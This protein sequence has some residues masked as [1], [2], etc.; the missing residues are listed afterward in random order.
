MSNP[1]TPAISA[2]QRVL[3][4]L[5]VRLGAARLPEL[6]HA[7][8]LTELEVLDAL[9]ELERCGQVAPTVWRLT[10]HRAA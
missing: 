5:R 1:T 8:G 6:A 4:V 7:I 10:D 9:Y 2:D 3:G